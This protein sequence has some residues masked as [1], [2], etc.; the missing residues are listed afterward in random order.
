MQS[1]GIE[2]RI[3]CGHRVWK[4]G[5]AA[6]GTP[7]VQPVAASGAWSAEDTFTAKIC[8]SQTPFVYTVSLKFSEGELRFNA[9]ANVGFGP[10]KEPELVG[11]PVAS[12]K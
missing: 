11:R 9:E 4:K 10:T 7:A 1:N 8:L 2:T 12:E 3:D 5:Q 6:W